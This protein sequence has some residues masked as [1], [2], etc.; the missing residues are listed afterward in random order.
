MAS[1]GLT[2]LLLT[3]LGGADTVPGRWEQRTHQDAGGERSYHLYQ[4]RAWRGPGPRALL[5]ALH[6]CTQTAADFA[7]GT[8]LNQLAEEQGLLVLYPE[9]PASANAQRCWNWFLPAH[10][11]RGGGEPAWIAGLARAVAEEHGADPARVYLVGISAGGAMAVATAAAYPELFAAVGVHSGVPH[12]AAA[13]VQGALRL[14]RHG[15]PDAA[16]VAPRVAAAMAGRLRLVPAVL[17]HGAADAVVHPA[18]QDA[19]AGQWLALARAAGNPLAP[20][21]P[22]P[23]R[24]EPMPSRFRD[25]AAR[26][27]LE[28][29][30]VEGVGH[31]WSGGSPRGS[32]TH[33]GGPD[34]SREMLR[35]LLSHSL[36]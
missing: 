8:R 10:Q 20:D 23:G 32:Y 5:V 6:G 1:A 28:V 33:P 24:A 12:G 15:P 16:A 26:V 13:D 7:A 21:P 25:G 35:F 11:G 31:A 34:A 3:Q 18:N 36:P 14:M 19:L 29:W 9:Q 27:L 30:R 4:P 2:A 22:A 17:F